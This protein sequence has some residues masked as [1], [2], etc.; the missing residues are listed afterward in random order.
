MA[1]GL[2]APD[3]AFNDMETVI[4][5]SR[6]RN[7]PFTSAEKEKLFRLISKYGEVLENKEKAVAPRERSRAWLRITAEFNTHPCECRRETKQLRKMW[8]NVKFRLRKNKK[9]DDSDIVLRALRAL[10]GRPS[11]LLSTRPSNV[12]T[13]VC[14]TETDGVL[15]SSATERVHDDCLEEGEDVMEAH[16]V[17][18]VVTSPAA[19]TTTSSDNEPRIDDTSYQDKQSPTNSAPWAQHPGPAMLWEEDSGSGIVWGSEVDPP[20]CHC[21]WEEL[22]LHLAKLRAEMQQAH[23]HHLL[24]L[25]HCRR[26]Y[27]QEVRLKKKEGQLRLA[28]LHQELENARLVGLI[29]QKQLAGR[30]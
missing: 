26:D 21:K 18:T 19:L 30:P 11:E 22:K 14:K 1:T 23:D 25:E 27:E 13:A 6:C 10:F 8:D 4:R 28:R 5:Q 12:F 17:L 7:V 9:F 29:L 3:H 2:F 16:A 15:H 24:Q 20:G